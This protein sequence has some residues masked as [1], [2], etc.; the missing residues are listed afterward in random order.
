M[1]KVKPPDDYPPEEGRYLRGNDYSPVA[2]IAILNT[3]D[4]KIPQ[5]ITDIFRGGSIDLKW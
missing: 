3:Y 5:R 4:F 2:V 1:L